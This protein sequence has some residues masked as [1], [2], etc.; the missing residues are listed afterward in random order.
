M[1][2][3]S[4]PHDPKYPLRHFRVIEE[5]KSLGSIFDDMDEQV[6]V[7]FGPLSTGLNVGIKS[8]ADR[9]AHPSIAQYDYT[10]PLFKSEWIQ[11]YRPRLR[12]K[13]LDIRVRLYYW[14]HRG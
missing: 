6:G 3:K 4:L 9:S 2:R 13:W 5:P 8:V 14:R 7:F 10:I 1:K 12:D 11:Y